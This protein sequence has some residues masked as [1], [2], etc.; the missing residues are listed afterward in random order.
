MK[1]LAVAVAVLDLLVILVVLAV[2]VLQIIAIQLF[3]RSLGE[4]LNS[5]YLVLEDWGIMAA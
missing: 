5:P 4:M 1:P 3:F 2:A